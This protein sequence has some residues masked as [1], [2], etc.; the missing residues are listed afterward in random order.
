MNPR[1]PRAPR[2]AGIT[3]LEVALLMAGLAV[4]AALLLPGLM[5]PRVHS[6]RINCVNNLKQVG[7]GY[8]LWALD[9]QD[10]FPMALTASSG[11]T[12]DHPRRT[13]AWPELRP[14]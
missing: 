6:C 5:R 2:C 4:L 12:L 8:R 10:R 13:E 3:L 14:R 7:L 11:G 1:N 9:H